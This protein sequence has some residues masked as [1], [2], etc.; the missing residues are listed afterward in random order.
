MT[1]LV[2]HSVCLFKIFQRTNI[3]FSFRL[4]V[5]ANAKVSDLFLTTK[6]FRS[7]FF[8]KFFEAV[9]S[10]IRHKRLILSRSLTLCKVR[11]SVQ[12]H[13]LSFSYRFAIRISISNVF[14]SRK[15]MQRYDLF[16]NPQAFDPL[17]C[18]IFI[19]FFLNY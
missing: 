16:L 8:E 18:K 9:K 3:H 1:T 11:Y 19:I 4:E 6:F 15:R 14:P 13:L 17:F 2:Q 12:H 5:K 10:T 7:F